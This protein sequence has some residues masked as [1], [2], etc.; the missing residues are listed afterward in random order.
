MLASLHAYTLTCLHAYML[1]YLH[2]YVLA[3]SLLICLNVRMIHVFMLAWFPW[4]RRTCSYA[5]NLR[6]QLTAN[7][8][9]SDPKTQCPHLITA[10]LIRYRRL[11]LAGHWQ[12]ERTTQCSARIS[13]ACRTCGEDIVPARVLKKGESI[14][15]DLQPVQF[16]NVH[17]DVFMTDTIDLGIGKHYVCWSMVRLGWHH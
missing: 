8:H 5:G 15:A 11:S 12:R 7:K 3:W 10:R 13:S 2:V 16:T 6:L 17:H 9:S 14:I 1:T 4:W